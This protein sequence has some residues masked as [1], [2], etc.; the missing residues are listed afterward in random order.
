MKRLMASL[1]C[2]TLL[3]CLV[4]IAAIAENGDEISL[5]ASYKAEDGSMTISWNSASVDGYILDSATINQK[6]VSHPQVKNTNDTSSFTVDGFN[7]LVGTNTIQ[8]HFLPENE[9]GESLTA[10]MEKKLAVEDLLGFTFSDPDPIYNAS[11]GA[12]SLTYTPKTAGVEMT[13]IEVDGNAS[14]R[15]KDNQGKVTATISNLGYGSHSLTYYF[16]TPGNESVAYTSSRKLDR[17]GT[18][19]LSMKLSVENGLVVATLTDQNGDP[20][21][22]YTVELYLSGVKQRSQQSDASGRVVFNVAAPDDR[23]TVKCVAPSSKEGAVSYVGCEEYLS[24]PITDKTTAT[25]TTNG[26]TTTTDKTTSSSTNTTNTTEGIGTTAGT[27]GTRYPTVMAAGTTATGNGYVAISTTFDTGIASAF[28]LTEAEFSS[29][30]RLLMEPD[31]YQT[32]VGSSSDVT[33]VLSFRSSSLQANSSQIAAAL[34]SSDALNRYSAG[35]ATSLTFDLSAYL[36]SSID[37][38][39]LEFSLPEGKLKLQ[40]PVPKS[41]EGRDLAIAV[42]TEDGLQTPALVTPENGII[43]I[44]TNRLASLTLLSFPKTEEASQGMPP[45]VIVLIVVGV[46]LVV[47]AGVLIF[48]FF[49]RKPKNPDPEDDETENTGNEVHERE[50]NPITSQTAFGE[51]SSEE[52]QS[53][54]INQR[55]AKTND[56]ASVRELERTMVLDFSA[57]K[58]PDQNKPDKDT[59]VPGVS[60]GSF[61]EQNDKKD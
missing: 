31:Y 22:D 37:Q 5:N 56:M 38:S 48:F 28:G 23:S 20:V 59:S 24:T 18:L 34:A 49:I 46:V 12:F 3:L 19:T 9:G 54:A 10:S 52:E 55:T 58:A 33:P 6:T 44:E 11:S 42:I 51:E 8:C 17:A 36:L 29:R 26:K 4:P 1:A 2:L 61:A 43:T 47:G 41:M 40:L 14:Y 60:L 21:S 53:V 32:L 15:V 50:D 30:V 39:M 25:N 7:A 16:R 13:T 27:G 45:L 35:D 57:Q